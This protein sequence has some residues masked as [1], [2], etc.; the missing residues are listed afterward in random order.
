LASTFGSS[1][2]ASDDKDTAS[3]L[4]DS[5][6]LCV[7]HSPLDVHRPEFGQGVENSTEICALWLSAAECSCHVFPNN[8]SWTASVILQLLDDSNG[9]VEQAGACLAL[10]HAGALAG[11]R[12]VLARRTERQNVT[13]RKIRTTNV[14][15][16]VP[17][18]NVRPMA[19]QHRLALVVPLDLKHGGHPGA[20][21]P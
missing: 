14:R 11:N 12:Q 15:Y 16:V 21:Q 17:L 3:A 18:R 19:T 6:E 1:T 9:F 7:Q 8:P 13:S 2:E 10:D 5:E 4:G 20:L